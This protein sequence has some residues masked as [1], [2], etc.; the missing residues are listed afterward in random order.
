MRPIILS[1]DGEFTRTPV[2]LFN[3]SDV[4]GRESDVY[5]SKLLQTQVDVEEK[6]KKIIKVKNTGNQL[7]SELDELGEIK[8]TFMYDGGIRLS[9]KDLNDIVENLYLVDGSSKTQMNTTED[10]PYIQALCHDFCYFR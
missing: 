7:V 2:Q 9:E 5:I 8:D 10:N 1:E 4:T 6:V 3:L